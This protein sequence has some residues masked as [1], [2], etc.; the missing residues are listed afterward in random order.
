MSVECSYDLGKQNVEHNAII[1]SKFVSGLVPGEVSELVDEHDLGSCAERR[2]GS[3]PP[4][5]TQLLL[6]IKHITQLRTSYLASFT[7]SA[8]YISG[9]ANICR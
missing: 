3:N 4:F 1:L 7:M 2:G 8:L 5:P 9:I 6:R